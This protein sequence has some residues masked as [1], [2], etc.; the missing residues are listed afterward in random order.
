MGGGNKN[1]VEEGRIFRGGGGHEEIFGWLG[2][3][4]PNRE[5][6]VMSQR[7]HIQTANLIEI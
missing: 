3:T 5:K 7:I 4:P 2:E 1:L 6:A